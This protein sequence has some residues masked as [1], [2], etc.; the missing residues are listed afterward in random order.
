MRAILLILII[1]V[2]ALLIALATGFLNITQT[3]TAKAPDISTTGNGVAAKGGRT[4]TFDIETGSVSVGTKPANV[5]VP[6]V[7]VNPP[8]DE[9]ANQQHAQNVTTNAG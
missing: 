6:T 5:T 4:P 8:A 1:V 3:R 2:I 9:S 7:Q